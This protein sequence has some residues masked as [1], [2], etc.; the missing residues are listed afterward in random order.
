MFIFDVY[1]INVSPTFGHNS[2]LSV[3]F[4]MKNA[5]RDSISVYFCNIDILFK[6]VLD[7]HSC[8][9]FNSHSSDY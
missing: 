1:Q 2:V 6:N 3:V 5:D 7:E 9:V 8:S 4:F